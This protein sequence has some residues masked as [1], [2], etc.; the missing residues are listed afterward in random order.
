MTDDNVG[1]LKMK[2]KNKLIKNWTL[3][4]FFNLVQPSEETHAPLISMEAGRSNQS[5]SIYPEE[6]KT[7]MTATIT[8]DNSFNRLS[9]RKSGGQGIISRGPVVDFLPAYDA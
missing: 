8:G 9:V 1:A 4:S 6:L 2:V 7:P 5:H 3:Q